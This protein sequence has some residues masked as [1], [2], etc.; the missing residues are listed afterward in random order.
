MT[1]NKYE[2]EN[3]ICC[4][5]QWVTDSDYENN[6]EPCAE[7]RKVLINPPPQDGNC[8]ICGRHV[9][10]LESFGGSGNPLFGDFFGA[11]LIKTFREDYPGYTKPSWECRD[12]VQRPGPLW[13][14]R[15]E[16]RL[17]RR[18]T[19]TEI[20]EARREWDLA[21]NQPRSRGK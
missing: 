19:D 14:I 10:E 13:I 20:S 16:D 1:S 12:C 9:S 8:Q 2:F 21:N 5:P 6:S 11:K 7:K 15:E 3:D 4:S 18:L 17:G